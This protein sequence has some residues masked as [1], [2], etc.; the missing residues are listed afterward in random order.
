M[1]NINLVAFLAYPQ[2]VLTLMGIWPRPALKLRWVYNV[3]GFLMTFVVSYTFMIVLSGGIYE[4]LDNFE[5]TA[6]ASYYAITH[7]TFII[8]FTTFVTRRKKFLRL[9]QSMKEP[10][11]TQHLQEQ[12]NYQS[13]FL[14]FTK[15]YMKGYYMCCSFV[16]IFYGLYPIF[17]QTNTA[18]LPMKTWSLL[19]VEHST[20]CYFVEY[21]YQMLALGVAIGTNASYDVLTSALMNS[22]CVEIQILKDNLQNAT[23]RTKKAFGKTEENEEEA[24]ELLSK[25]EDDFVFKEIV[26]SIEHHK[27]IR[28][29]VAENN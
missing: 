26:K 7:L 17:E 28:R 29:Y 5:E 4:V 11:F 18:G 22:A 3:Y 2:N 19:D 9:L 23:R 13:E 8:K 15:T 10:V 21:L 14:Q 1:D 20:F 12:E 25:E 24:I 6:D 16:W 27:A